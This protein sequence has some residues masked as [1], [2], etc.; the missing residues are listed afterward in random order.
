MML[1]GFL[2]QFSLFAFFGD[3]G[4]LLS[5]FFKEILPT[6]HFLI[7]ADIMLIAGTEH[8]I[9]WQAFLVSELLCVIHSPQ[10]CRLQIEK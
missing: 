9:K 3:P 6:H 8:S 10:L 4:N 1:S 7:R 5:D 2:T